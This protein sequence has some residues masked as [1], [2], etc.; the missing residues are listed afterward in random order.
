MEDLVDPAT[1]RVPRD[2]LRRDDLR[3]PG[4]VAGLRRAVTRIVL[5]PDGMPLD[6]GRTCGCAPARAPA[7][8]VRDGGCVFAGC[9]APTWW[10]DVHHLLAWIDGGETD[11]ANAALLCDGTR[12]L[13]PPRLP[14]GATTRG[15]MAHLATPTH[16]DPHRTPTAPARHSSCGLTDRRQHASRTTS[17]SCGSA[18]VDSRRAWTPGVRD[19]RAW[20]P[21]AWTRVSRRADEPGRS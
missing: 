12:T 15:P 16:R 4:A 5:G 9:G 19:S 18:C 13:C 14:R 21:A 8:E 17:R 7:A 10:C 1:G 11:L 6:H 2:G 20:T 3:R